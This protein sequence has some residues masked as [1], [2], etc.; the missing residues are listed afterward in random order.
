MLLVKKVRDLTNTTLRIQNAREPYAFRNNLCERV[1][2]L[3][4]RTAL[5]LQTSTI[6]FQHLGDRGQYNIYMLVTTYRCKLIKVKGLLSFLY[7]FT[8]RGGQESFTFIR[9]L[10]E[11]AASNTLCASKGPSWARYATAGF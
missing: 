7:T 10:L 1:L 3:D 8:V 6:S 2:Q 4:K 9:L 5:K 11:V